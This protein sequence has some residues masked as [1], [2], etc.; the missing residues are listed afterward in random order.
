MPS[1]FSPNS[2]WGNSDA[3]GIEEELTTPLGQTCRA[4]KVQIIQL[5]EAGVLSQADSLT[6]IAQSHVKEKKKSGPNGPVSQELDTNS[7]MADAEGLKAIIELCDR[8]IPHIVVSPRVV[9]HFSERKVGNTVAQKILTPEQRAE[10]VAEHPGTVFTDQID[11]TDKMWLFDWATGGLRSM[12]PFRN[13]SSA[14]V[15]GVVHVKG[16]KNTPKRN[17]RRS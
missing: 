12:Q 7:L 14:D 8:T 4:K 10:I 17:R 13:G 9:L 1:D 3:A 6:A 2:V 11:F 16:S 15:G 5:I